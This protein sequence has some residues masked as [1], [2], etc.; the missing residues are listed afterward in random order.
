MSV[1]H[2][3]LLCLVANQYPEGQEAAEARHLEHVRGCGT[4]ID[5]MR[6][7]LWPADVEQLS[8]EDLIPIHQDKTRQRLAA[9]AE[10]Q[11]FIIRE[12]SIIRR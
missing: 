8:A 4:C 3:Q 12:R 7:S 11:G 6:K 2:D 1:W 5:D 9:Q 10:S